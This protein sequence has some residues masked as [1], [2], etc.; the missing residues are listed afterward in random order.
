MSDWKLKTPVAFFIFKRRD[1]TEKV[2]AEIARARPPRLFV[3]A[4]GPRKDVP[5]EAEACTATR[6]VIDQVDWDCEVQAYYSDVNMGCERRMASGLDWV[7][8]QVEEAIIFEDDCL[9]QPTFFRFCEELLARYR[10]DERIA[11]ISGNNFQ[12][13]RKRTA[14]S[15]YFSR[16]PHIWGWA[17][18]RRAWENYDA[19]MKTWPEI[20]GGGWLREYS[21]N[22]RTIKFRLNKFNDLYEGNGGSWDGKW[23]FACWLHGQLAVLPNVNLVSNIGFGKDATHTV[24]VN[25]VC[26][27]M[28]TEPIEFPLV[29][30]H[31]MLRDSVAD[32]FTERIIF[33]YITW[34]L[35]LKGIL[36]NFLVKIRVINPAMG[37][38]DRE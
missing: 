17:T 15:Y 31:F 2:F 6:A 25:N 19:N 36:Y 20:R 32:D 1:A 9:P 3:I 22:L 38:A 23:T 11:M 12:F 14:Y 34:P 5:G 27:A 24:V 10:D 7:F 16:Y 4:D 33:P 28:K 8:S 35:Y 26:S 13:G 29:H 37:N 18:W 30:P 21:C